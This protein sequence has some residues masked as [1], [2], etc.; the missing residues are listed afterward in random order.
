[1]LT[2]HEVQSLI[3]VGGKVVGVRMLDKRGKREV[4][5]YSSLVINAAGIWG[6]LV[7]KKAGITINMFPAKGALLIFGHRINNMVINRC[8]KPAQHPPGF[9]MRI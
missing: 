5:A 8:R 7:A 9:P 6:Y 4:E 2:F 3:I 1:M